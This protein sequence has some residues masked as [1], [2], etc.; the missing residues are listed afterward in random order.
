MKIASYVITV[1]TTKKIV[2]NYFP[3][4]ILRNALIGAMAHLYCIR[5]REENLRPGGCAACDDVNGCIYHKLNLPTPDRK[6]PKQQP[7]L[8]DAD[9]LEYNERFNE[10][11]IFHFRL[12]LV[13]WANDYLPQWTEAIKHAGANMGIG[14]NSGRYQLLGV[15][16]DHML[17][18]AGESGN[19]STAKLRFKYLHFYNDKRKVPQS[20]MPF[21][22]LLR[23]IV[24]RYNGLN[25]LYGDGHD[26]ALA[27]S[28]PV[29]I[30]RS[31]FSILRLLYPPGGTTAY[32]DCYKGY[33]QYA[34]Q[35][36][37]Y[38]NILET[39]SRLGIGQL[40][41]AGLGRYILEM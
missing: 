11:G 22:D 1:K 23:R 10:N 12:T 36:Q 39:G 14:Q 4:F 27:E 8:I 21:E 25:A 28:V 40:T 37:P 7:Y 26:I 6:A 33:I 13:G 16:P 41:P 17:P 35:L 15:A 5:Q 31:R 34:G 29:E 3:G 20:G 9:D 24:R 32:Y 19:A 18:G 2:F 38:A 30:T